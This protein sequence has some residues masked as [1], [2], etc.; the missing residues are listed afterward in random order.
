[1]STVAEVTKFYGWGPRDAMGL[2]WSEL[3]WWHGEAMRMQ[4]G[5]KRDLSG[6]SSDY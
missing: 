5:G 6:T 4:S 2:P 3:A 1:M